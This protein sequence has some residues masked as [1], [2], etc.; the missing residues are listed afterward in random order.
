MVVVVSSVIS[1]PRAGQSWGRGWGR[2][3]GDGPEESRP[4]GPRGL[5]GGPG[6]RTTTTVAVA[7]PVIGLV[8]PPSQHAVTQSA[9]TYSCPLSS[10]LLPPPILAGSRSLLSEATDLDLRETIR[11]AFFVN[12]SCIHTRVGWL[13]VVLELNS[14]TLPVRWQLTW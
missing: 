14:K 9:A 10:P 11:I 5:V 4:P 2:R 6:R 13:S 1:Q 8:A 12:F 7:S 3:S